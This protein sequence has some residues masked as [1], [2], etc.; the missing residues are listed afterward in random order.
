ME[1]TLDKTL[2]SLLFAAGEPLT[3]ER[4]RKLIN[5]SSGDI[6]AALQKLSLRLTDGIILVRT[7]TT[8][9][10]AVSPDSEEVLNHMLGDPEDR[11]IGQAGL[12]VLAIILYQGASSRSTIDYIRGVNSTSSIRT[13]LMRNLVERTK[14]ENGR[15]IIYQ[16]TVELLEHLGVTNT[17]EL[18]DAEELKNALSAF[19]A[20]GVER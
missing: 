18:P 12:E 9:A 14:G 1:K 16:P 8:A 7:A 6:E 20:R 15:E 10:L 2:E 17:N 11:E 3:I 5:C 19:V 4:L 13:L